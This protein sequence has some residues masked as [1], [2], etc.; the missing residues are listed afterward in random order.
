MVRP[1]S[2]C[3]LSLVFLQLQYLMA[4]AQLYHIPQKHAA[5][6]T[7]IRSVY[8]WM[9]QEDLSISQHRNYS[10]PCFL[11]DMCLFHVGCC[12]DC[13]KRG[14]EAWAKGVEKG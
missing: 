13:R 10:G 11:I 6:V 3:T 5:A 12:Q 1:I 14:R 8:G 2:C 4:K 9:V 7:L